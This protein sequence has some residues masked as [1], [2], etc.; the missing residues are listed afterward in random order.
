MFKR[1]RIPQRT[2]YGRKRLR[3]TAAV[4][5]FCFAAPVMAQPAGYLENPLDFAYDSGV[6]VVSGFHCTA[7]AIDIVFD[8]YDPI[9][10]ATGTPRGDTQNYCGRSDTG[11]SLL[12]NW[13]ILG[14]GQHTVRALADGVEFDSATITVSTFG[15]EFVSGLWLEAETTAWAAG[16]QVSLRWQESKQGFVIDEIED[17]EYGLPE[18]MAAL[19]G[20]WNGTWAS[21][22]GSGTIGFQ[23]MEGVTGFPRIENFLI[24]GTGCATSGW[25]DYDLMNLDDPLVEFNMNDGSR[26]VLE[27]FVTESF[28]TLGGVFYLEDG[29]CADTDGMFHMFK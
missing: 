21:P 4:I 22:L 18:V 1:T 26:L 15:E 2:E 3:S 6:S 23:V 9:P 28:T 25:A 14:P 16:K 19:T 5:A 7:Q 29:A 24:T 20:D 13:N 27:L 10:A 11:F 17:M 12:W 8:Q